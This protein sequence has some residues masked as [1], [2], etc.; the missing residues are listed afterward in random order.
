MYIE[1]VQRSQSKDLKY[2]IIIPTWNNLDYLRLV[3]RSIREH[4]KFNHQII[5]H[6]NEGHD[7]SYQWI[8]QQEDIDYVYSKENIGI[9]YALNLCRS[10][11][12]TE[13]LVYVND[14]MYVLPD[15]DFLLAQEIEKINSRKF[16]LSCTLIEPTYTSN[17]TIVA[18]FGKN[19]SEFREQELLATYKTLKKEDWI[20]GTWPINIIHVD[21]WDLVGGYSVEFSPGMYSDP[22]FSKKLWDLGIRYFKGLGAS[23]AY[24]FGSKSTKRSKNNNGHRMFLLKWGMT[25]KTFTT[26]YLKRGEKFKAELSEPTLNSFTV[27]LNKVKYIIAACNR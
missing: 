1:K 11:M 3:I 14:D 9:C 7:G 4:S 20:G 16:F 5:V 13:Y 25:S 19:I 17:C 22:D 6:I 18:D 8:R 26:L 10:L 2:S 15:W 12:K 23:R 24:H 21:N 27:I